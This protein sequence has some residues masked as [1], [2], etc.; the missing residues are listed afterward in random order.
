MTFVT[1]L[2]PVFVSGGTKVVDV[3]QQTLTYTDGSSTGLLGSV[4]FGSVAASAGAMPKDASDG[5]GVSGAK[6][7]IG[8]QALAT[9]Y[10]D[11]TVTGSP[12]AGAS[13]VTLDSNSACAAPFLSATPSGQVV[14]FTAGMVGDWQGT[15]APGVPTY[16]CL[17]HDG[18]TT[19]NSGKV[20]ACFDFNSEA[21]TVNLQLPKCGPLREV[22]KNGK[23]FYGYVIPKSG[24]VDKAF[25]R[26]YNK[27]TTAGKIRVT[28]YDQDGNMLGTQGSVVV[29]SAN[30]NPNQVA[31]VTVDEIQTATGGSFTAGRA[32]AV[33]DIELPEVEM[34]ATL[35]N[36]S[37]STSPL[38]N[39]STE[40]V[41]H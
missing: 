19:I 4:F 7:T 22:Q 13:K 34:I 2:K 12:I 18:A 40:A 37:V 21:T 8:G 9:L 5:L 41:N 32:H 39:F 15:A 24:G 10:L 6:A 36:T 3:A 17:M 26:F 31:I 33:F 1:A 35:R 16:V 28:L 30:F 29:E 23:T 27:S 14:T 20:T 11:M 25:F 38:T